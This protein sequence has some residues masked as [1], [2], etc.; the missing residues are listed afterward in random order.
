MALITPNTGIINPYDTHTSIVQNT[1][2]NGLSAGI[3]AVSGAHVHRKPNSV[4]KDFDGL[5]T[6]MPQDWMLTGKT[7]VTYKGKN[8]EKHC[9]S[10]C[11]N[12]IDT[13]QV[14]GSGESEKICGKLV[15]KM[16][17]EDFVIQDKFYVVLQVT[18]VLHPASSPVKQLERSL[19]K[20]GLDYIDIYLVHGPIHLQTYS[21]IAKGTAECVDKGLTKCRGIVFQSYSSLAQGRL[22]KKYSVENPPPKQHRSSSY[23]MKDIEPVIDVLRRIADKRGKSISSVALYYNLCKG[24][25]PVFGIRKSEQAE[26]SCQCLG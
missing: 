20:M 17:R 4:P 18:D 10:K 25:T 12:F 15:Q 8:G 19:K 11:I 2:Q 21:M 24:I 13:A 23:N 26:Q 5:A 9:V 14:Y 1:L 3:S 16:N 22:T 6:V 7:R